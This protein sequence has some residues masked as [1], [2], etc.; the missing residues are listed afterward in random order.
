MKRQSTCGAVILFAMAFATGARAEE[1]GDIFARKNLVAWCIVPFDSKKRGPAERAEMVA[2]LGITK[3]AYDWRNEHV[4]QFEEEI[5]EYK[6]H[7]LEYFAFWGTHAEATKLWAKHGLRPQVWVMCPSPAG[8]TQEERVSKAA[9]QLLGVAKQT[10]A[11]G[12]PLSLYNHGGWAGEPETMAAVAKELREKHEMPHVGIVYN[13]HHGHDHIDR[14]PAAL[15][16]MKPYLHCL[17]ITGMIKGGDKVGKKIIPLGAGDLDVQMLKAIRDSG[18]RGPIGIIGHTNDD[19]EERLKD[20]LDGL[21]W[22]LPQ[23]DGKPAGE[24]P[25]WRTYKG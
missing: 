17:N 22:L 16:L 2:R 18:Y 4:A 5:L 13:L 21:D 25:K 15:A 8:A 10:A 24:R 1:A 23:L 3:V 11:A 7:K 12:C 19:V 20:N 9:H 6:K 14:F